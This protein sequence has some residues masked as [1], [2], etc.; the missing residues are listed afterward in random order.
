[1]K[2]SCIA[3]PIFPP[4]TTRLLGRDMN[5]SCSMPSRYEKSMPFGLA[6]RITTRLSSALGMS[7]AMNG[8]EVSTVG[9]RWKLTWVRLNCGQMWFT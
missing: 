2:I 8:F 4:G 7:L 5:E 9:T 6:K 1:M 3:R